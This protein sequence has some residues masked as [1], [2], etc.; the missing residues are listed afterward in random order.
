MGLVLKELTLMV[1]KEISL[2]RLQIFGYEISKM[3]FAQRN[4]EKKRIWEI[5]LIW[6]IHNGKDLSTCT[7]AV[8]RRYNCELD[9]G[10]WLLEGEADFR[11]G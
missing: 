8:P 2:V 1:K 9:T 3:A 4:L 10:L 7:K 5:I 11:R 6:K